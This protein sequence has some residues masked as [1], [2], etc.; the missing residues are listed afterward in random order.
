M[1]EKN[2]GG[3][4]VPAAVA[5]VDESSDE[6]AVQ[7]VPE[8]SYEWMGLSNEWGVR[9]KPDEHGLRL[10]ALNVGI[11]GEVPE[12]WDDQTR[13]PRG[14]LPRPGI[15]P[16]PYNLRSKYQMWADCAADLYEEAIQ[17]RWIPA[18]DVPWSTLEPLPEDIERAVMTHFPQIPNPRNCVGFIVRRGLRPFEE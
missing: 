4:A 3:A 14:A 7:G 11:Y 12:V 9:V 1:A 16:L 8:P 13:R 18:T 10:S 6:E 17:R 15:P 5:G 2:S